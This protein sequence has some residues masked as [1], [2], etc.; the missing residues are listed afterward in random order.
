MKMLVHVSR[1]IT[2]VFVNILISQYCVNV[3]EYVVVTTE[4]IPTF[5][6]ALL[7]E[8]VFRQETDIEV[9]F[10]IV[11]WKCDLCCINGHNR[12][13]LC[14]SLFGN[15]KLRIIS[16]KKTYLADMHK[17]CTPIECFSTRRKVDAHS[18]FCYSFYFVWRVTIT[19]NGSGI[20]LVLNVNECRD[21][22]D[23]G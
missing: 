17:K 22:I 4:I 8:L 18:Q 5:F 10:V 9:E 1:V 3:N 14:Y 12:C 2:C 23:S 19:R 20:H 11:I 21:E 6:T 15:L 13:V 16:R 7:K